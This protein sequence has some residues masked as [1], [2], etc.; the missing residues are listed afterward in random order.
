MIVFDQPLVFVLLLG[1]GI[2]ALAGAIQRRFPPQKI[3]HFYGYRTTRSMK[4]QTVWDFAQRYSADKMMRLGF[5]MVAFALLALVV[6]LEWPKPWGVWL[7]IVIIVVAPILML[8]QVENELK[9][10]FPKE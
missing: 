6:D 9:K 5:W 3:N 10:R 2:F 1:G 8:L 7:G 4:N